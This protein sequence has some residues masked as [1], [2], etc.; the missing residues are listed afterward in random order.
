MLSAKYCREG[1]SDLTGTTTNPKSVMIPN[2][3]IL[4]FVSMGYRNP[5]IR[6]F[7]IKGMEV[8]CGN[9]HNPKKGICV[10]SHPHEVRG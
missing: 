9:K 6:P 1:R 5:A 8:S 4:I 7:T 10:T 3:Q 2:N